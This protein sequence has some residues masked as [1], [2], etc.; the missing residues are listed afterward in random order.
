[1]LIAA[2]RLRTVGLMVMTSWTAKST[3]ATNANTV[4]TNKNT[5]ALLKNPYVIL[6]VAI[7]AVVVMLVKAWHE[8]GAIRRRL[9]D[10]GE[11]VD[12]V[13]NSWDNLKDSVKGIIPD[14]ASGTQVLG[15]ANITGD[16]FR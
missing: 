13:A 11:I 8:S 10:L 16:T 15:S 2:E 5:L 6:A 4:A 3:A 12:K 1:M 14:L 7:A 9:E